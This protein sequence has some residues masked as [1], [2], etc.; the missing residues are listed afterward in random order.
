MGA[1]NPAKIGSAQR[2]PTRQAF[3][4]GDAPQPPAVSHARP[5]WAAPLAAAARDAAP[6]PA[7]LAVP[8]EPRWEPEAEPDSVLVPGHKD[9][10]CKLC[11]GERP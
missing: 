5:A 3:A 9:P 8:L 6:A 10:I 4:D 11:E 1:L 2:V 7:D